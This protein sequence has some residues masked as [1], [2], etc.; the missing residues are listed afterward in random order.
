MISKKQ[1]KINCPMCHHR[2]EANLYRFHCQLAHSGDVRIKEF[3]EQDE[4]F[5]KLPQLS[6]KISQGTLPEK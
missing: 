2:I 1:R 6:N 3:L 5:G 4:E